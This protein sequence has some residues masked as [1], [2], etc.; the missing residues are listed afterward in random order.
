[1]FLKQLT[2]DRLSSCGTVAGRDD[3]LAVGR[4][5][6]ARRVQTGHAGPL[7]VINYY[8]PLLIDFCPELAGQFVMKNIPASGEQA[9]DQKF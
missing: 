1:M 4:G 9:I 2:I 5:D 7:T 6:T 8:L 3:H